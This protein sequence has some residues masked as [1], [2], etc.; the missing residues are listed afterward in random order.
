MKYGK[1]RADTNLRVYIK[2]LR[3]EGAHNFGSGGRWFESTQLYQIRRLQQAPACSSRRACPAPS[4]NFGPEIPT[5]ERSFVRR[6]D[7]RLLYLNAI[8]PSGSEATLAI[9]DYHAA[10]RLHPCQ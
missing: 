10:M 4:D 7:S 1:Y 8:R 9:V 5:N 2:D 3:K 6:N